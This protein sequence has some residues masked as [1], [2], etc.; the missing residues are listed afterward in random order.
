MLFQ[1]AAGVA[2][3]KQRPPASCSPRPADWLH[4]RSEQQ[5]NDTV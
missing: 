2:Q 4:R 3:Q 1:P 5:H